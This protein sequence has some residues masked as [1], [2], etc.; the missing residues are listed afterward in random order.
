MVKLQIGGV[1]MAQ[2]GISSKMAKNLLD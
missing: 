1:M 2:L